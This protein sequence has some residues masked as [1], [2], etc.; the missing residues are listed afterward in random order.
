MD[1]STRESHGHFNADCDVVLSFGR[2]RQYVLTLKNKE[3]RRRY[4]QFMLSMSVLPVI[5]IV[6]FP[7]SMHSN[8]HIRQHLVGNMMSLDLLIHQQT[9]QRVLILSAQDPASKWKYE[10]LMFISLCVNGNLPIL[11]S[12]FMDNRFDIWKPL[13]YSQ[14]AA[15]RI[16]TVEYMQNP[17]FSALHTSMKYWNVEQCEFALQSGLSE[18]IMSLMQLF[19]D[20]RR[21]YQNLGTVNFRIGM[22]FLFRMLHVAR[23]HDCFKNDF[24]EYVQSFVSQYDE[25][26]RDTEQ[27][28]VTQE[29]TILRNRCD[30]HP[31]R[32]EQTTKSY[33]SSCMAQPIKKQSMY[34][35]KGCKMVKYC[36]RNHQKKHW[37]LIHSQQCKAVSAI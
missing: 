9:T 15:L 13:L 27:Q 36:C 26:L 32:M 11:K 35:C 37:K 24:Y 30:W 12:V 31:C 28:R 3:D 14:I 34:L 23:H 22:A 25:E 4:V 2:Y 1:D 19:G 17:V 21:I 10:N 8:K 6:P 5:R 20:K 33:Q 7:L 18:M 29:F 16:H